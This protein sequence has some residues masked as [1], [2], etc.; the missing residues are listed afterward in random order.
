MNQELRQWL[1]Q[2]PPFPGL[3]GRGV[4]LPDQQALAESFSDNCPPDAIENL[5]RGAAD[6]FRVLRLHQLP[7][8]E[9]RWTYSGALVVAHRRHDGA[10]FACLLQPDLTPEGWE[11]LDR[12]CKAFTILGASTN[13][14][15][16]PGL[17]F[18]APR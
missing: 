17:G 9:L 8:E 10:V 12:Q 14:P 15:S 2:E 1:R 13:S 18:T 16:Q 7:C 3:W 11:I 5:C 6:T 4:R